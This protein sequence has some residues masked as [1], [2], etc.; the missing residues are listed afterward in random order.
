MG[1]VSQKSALEFENK[2]LKEKI[3]EIDRWA[4]HLHGEN[5]EL[6]EWIKKIEVHSDS[7]ADRVAEQALKLHEYEKN[8]RKGVGDGA[9]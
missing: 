2:E 3:E 4:Y 7:L 9:E 5:R 6:K 8:S 1:R